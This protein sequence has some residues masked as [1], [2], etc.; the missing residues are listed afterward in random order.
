MKKKENEFLK[1]KNYKVRPKVFGD[2]EFESIFNFFEIFY[3]LLENFSKK[4]L[5]I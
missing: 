1:V 4:L 5:Y 2:E 3:Y